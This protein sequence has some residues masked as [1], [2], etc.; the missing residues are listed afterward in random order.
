MDN[1]DCTVEDLQMDR[2]GMGCK[3]KKNQGPTRKMELPF[4]KQGRLRRRS[5]EGDHQES[6]FGSGKYKI[7]I[8]DP[9]PGHVQLEDAFH[10]IFSKTKPNKNSSEVTKIKL[11]KTENNVTRSH[12]W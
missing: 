5:V 6:G 3:R 10:I 2:L 12:Y 11:I 1:K 4:L 9:T 8:R 7:P